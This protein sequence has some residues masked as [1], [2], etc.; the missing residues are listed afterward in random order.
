MNAL[1]PRNLSIFGGPQLLKI[2]KAIDLRRQN[3]ECAWTRAV[4]QPKASTSHVLLAQ[5]QQTLEKAGFK[6]ALDGI[7]YQTVSSKANPWTPFGAILRV[8]TLQAHDSLA[9]RSHHA[10]DMRKC[11]GGVQDRSLPRGGALLVLW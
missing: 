5:P 3:I 9:Q 4:V 11:V 7:N 10:P 6:T 1:L 8:K 2:S